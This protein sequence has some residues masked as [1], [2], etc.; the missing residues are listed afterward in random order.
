MEEQGLNPD[1]NYNKIDRTL[2]RRNTDDIYDYVPIEQEGA[3]AKKGKRVK[4]NHKN[5]N[6]LK[7]LRGL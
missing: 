3:F 4:K 6:I 7:K 1:I 2:N 5:S